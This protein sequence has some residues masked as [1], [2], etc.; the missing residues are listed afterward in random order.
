MPPNVLSFQATVRK[1]NDAKFHVDYSLGARIGLKTSVV[2]RPDG[3]ESFNIEYRDVVLRGTVMLKKGAP[4][5]I[6]KLNGKE[7]KISVAGE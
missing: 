5:T 2:K 6:S 3:T 4:V 7:L 1:E